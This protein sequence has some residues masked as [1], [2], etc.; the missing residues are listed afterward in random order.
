VRRFGEQ[1]SGECAFRTSHRGHHTTS[2]RLE[3]V[4]CHI[5]KVSDAMC[6]DDIAIMMSAQCLLCLCWPLTSIPT[7][8][9]FCP[10]R[11]LAVTVNVC[12]WQVP[13]RLQPSLNCAWL[14][15]PNVCQHNTRVWPLRHAPRGAHESKG[16]GLPFTPS[17]S[18]SHSKTRLL[19]CTLVH[20]CR[21]CTGGTT[22]NRAINFQ[23]CSHPPATRHCHAVTVSLWRLNVP[24]VQRVTHQLS[25][26]TKRLAPQ[27]TKDTKKHHTAVVT[28]AEATPVWL[29]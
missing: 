15:Q 10:S 27:K 22:V 17:P 7:P 3:A 19:A 8:K 5:V 24:A 23:R 2:T 18:A 12:A 28:R 26:C 1:Q 16:L 29:H 11:Q 13:G 14:Q 9:C 21:G 6:G 4:G 20:R 25:Q